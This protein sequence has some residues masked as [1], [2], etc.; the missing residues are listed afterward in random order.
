MKEPHGGSRQRLALFWDEG[1]VDRCPG[2]N[3][4][5]TTLLL[6]C[7]FWNPMNTNPLQCSSFSSL[8]KEPWALESQL[9]MHEKSHKHSPPNR[10]QR[11]PFASTGLL[12]LFVSAWHSH[13]LD[14]L[15]YSL[16]SLLRC[17]CPGFFFLL[18]S[19]CNGCPNQLHP[20]HLQ[21]WTEEGIN[22][23]FEGDTLLFIS[24]T[25]PAFGNL[26]LHTAHWLVI[27]HITLLHCLSLPSSLSGCSTV[28]FCLFNQT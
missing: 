26:V 21:Q 24:L 12:P 13:R 28:E 9:G 25:S 19:L 15:S 10:S 3:Q 18:L 4:R 8:P 17:N 2:R 11:R 14:C 7:G 6:S 27:L 20:L 5:R 1:C 22:H 16:P 23:I